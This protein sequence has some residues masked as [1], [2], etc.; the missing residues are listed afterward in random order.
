MEK[1]FLAAKPMAELT[2]TSSI[3][4][5]TCTY[6]RHKSSRKAKKT[7]TQKL[8]VRPE[9]AW[10]QAMSFRIQDRLQEEME[11]PTLL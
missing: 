11:S 1:L 6:L 10:K 8:P 5:M 9:P 7:E 4:F 3:K 2:I